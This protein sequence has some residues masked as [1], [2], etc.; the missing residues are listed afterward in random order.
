MLSQQE[1]RPVTIYGMLVAHQFNEM[2]Q[3]CFRLVAFEVR[4]II[5]DKR[6]QKRRWRFVS[7]SHLA[8][9]IL[10]IALLSTLSGHWRLLL[11]TT[12]SG[13]YLF[14][15]RAVSAPL[16]TAYYSG[17][18]LKPNGSGAGSELVT[19]A[20]ASLLL[21]AAPVGVIFTTVT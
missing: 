6:L 8:D 5:L 21:K 12:A 17:G 14:L 11:L 20:E 7:T 4:R 16:T 1:G 9:P 13:R 19:S 15:R 3:G 2:A 18:T 10:P